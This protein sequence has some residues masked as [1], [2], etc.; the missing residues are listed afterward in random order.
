MAHFIL[1]RNFFC[2]PLPPESSAGAINKYFVQAV[3][4]RVNISEYGHT[5]RHHKNNSAK[6]Y[7]YPHQMNWQVDPASF[8][9]PGLFH[10]YC[11]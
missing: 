1:F 7:E 6:R 11:F 5:N 4:D 9:K 2:N 10:D 8:F 3:A